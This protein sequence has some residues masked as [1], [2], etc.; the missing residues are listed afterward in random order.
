MKRALYAVAI[1]MAAAGSSTSAHHSYSA[2]DTT[3]LVDI[4]GTVDE[5]VWI[6]PHS[7]LVVRTD[8]ARVYTAEWRAPIGLERVGIE[9]DTLKRGERIVISGNP[10]RDIDKNGIVNLK[11]VRRLT[12][13]WK[14]PAQS[15]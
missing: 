7:L 2:Y 13:G 10:H 6:A 15:S 1:I 8:E 4:E 3:R 11:S 9:R 14:W 5:F 12:D